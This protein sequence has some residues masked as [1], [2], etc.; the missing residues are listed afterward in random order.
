MAN[1][2]KKEVRL[3]NEN[4]SERTLIF[5]EPFVKFEVCG[6]CEGHGMIL[7][8]SIG[9]HAYSQE[10][11]DEAF[12]DMDDGYF[13]SRE[14]YFKRGGIFDV[15]CPECKGNKVVPVLVEE[16]FDTPLKKKIYKRIMDQ[17]ES[18]AEYEREC[19]REREMGY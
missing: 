1:E 18:D 3:Y 13:N 7:N 11:F 10:E 14:E 2:L 16:A 5:R 17:M 9:E 19:R 8:P 15:Q 6:R 4:G 12:P